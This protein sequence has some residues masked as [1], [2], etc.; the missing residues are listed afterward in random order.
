M[1]VS[2]D[3]SDFVGPIKPP[4]LQTLAG[5]SEQVQVKGGDMYNRKS[6]MTMDGSSP[7]TYYQEHG[8]GRAA[9]DKNSFCFQ[10]ASKQRS[11]S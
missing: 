8:M 11:P 9:L 6:E 3:A 5:L 4:P 1:S 7:K 2:F 10:F